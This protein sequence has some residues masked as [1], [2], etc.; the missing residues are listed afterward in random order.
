[1]LPSNRAFRGPRGALIQHSKRMG[2]QGPAAPRSGGHL[3]LH[4]HFHMYEAILYL[5][6]GSQVS[7]FVAFRGG[8]AGRL[9]CHLLR[10]RFAHR[11]LG[12]MCSLNGLHLLPRT[13]PCQRRCKASCRSKTPEAKVDAALHDRP[14][15]RSPLVA[16]VHWRR[17][18]ASTSSQAALP[19]RTP[20]VSL[21]YT[22]LLNS[23]SAL[24]RALRGVPGT[25]R[26]SVYMRKHSK[27]RPQRPPSPGTAGGVHVLCFIYMIRH[28]PGPPETP[29]KPDLKRK[30]HSAKS[31][32]AFGHYG[33]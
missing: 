4:A 11:L 2:V 3:G 33:C 15:Q 6:C 23:A 9:Q 30:H 18:R 27:R 25:T 31:Q 12:T 17:H 8:G 10:C 26:G 1:M 7:Y 28:P 19:T 20:K 14:P 16:V 32:K 5:R 22:T 29:N 21:H 13:H 24:E